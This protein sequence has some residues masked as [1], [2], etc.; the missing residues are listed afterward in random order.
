MGNDQTE[1]GQ[2]LAE[3]LRHQMYQETRQFIGIGV[4]RP[5]E[6]IEEEAYSEGL[7]QRALFYGAPL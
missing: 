3:H 4:S 6:K 1:N 7:K 5:P 2:E